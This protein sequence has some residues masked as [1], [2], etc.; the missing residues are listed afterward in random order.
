[1]RT[2]NEVDGHF[3]ICVPMAMQL[4]YPTLCETNQMSTNHKMKKKKSQKY[5]LLQLNP[6]QQINM[7][8]SRHPCHYRS[9]LLFIFDC[10]EFVKI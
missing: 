5:F 6:E 3:C 2:S 8:G 4:I 10:S 7:S 9:K 1:M